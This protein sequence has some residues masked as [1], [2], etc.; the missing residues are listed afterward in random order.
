M[1]P[2]RGQVRDRPRRLCDLAHPLPGFGTPSVRSQTLPPPPSSTPPDSMARTGRPRPSP[3]PPRSSLQPPSG[4]QQNLVKTP[5]APGPRKLPTP[6]SSG[7][8]RGRGLSPSYSTPSSAGSGVTSTQMGLTPSSSGV[9]HQPRQQQ[10]GLSATPPR[11]GVP[12][13]RMQQSPQRGLTPSGTPR[14]APGSQIMP[15]RRTAASP[16]RQQSKTQ[17][18]RKLVASSEDDWLEGCY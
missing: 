11:A 12:R 4:A 14:S 10:G 1:L 2:Q 16:N 9:G 15:P 18:R 6:P 8:L 5:S 17:P 13:P 3:S 7:G